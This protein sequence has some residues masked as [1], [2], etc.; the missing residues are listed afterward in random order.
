MKTEFRLID[1]QVYRIGS[2]VSKLLQFARPSEYSG[3]ANVISPA[4]VVQTAWC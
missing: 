4:E 3:A 2:I 1:D